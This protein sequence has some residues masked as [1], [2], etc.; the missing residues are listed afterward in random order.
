MAKLAK[1]SIEKNRSDDVKQ[2]M[3]QAEKREQDLNF[4]IDQLEQRN[5]KCS[6]YFLMIESTSYIHCLFERNSIDICGRYCHIVSQ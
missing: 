4:M 2:V 6:R 3:R 1:E 5:S